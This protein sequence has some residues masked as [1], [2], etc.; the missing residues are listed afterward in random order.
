VK[1]VSLEIF[2]NPATH[3][4]SHDPEKEARRF[5]KGDIHNVHLTSNLS[6]DLIGDEYKI[7]GG[8]LQTPER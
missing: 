1:D 4:L 5:V 8:I 7:R 6:V 3:D 2:L